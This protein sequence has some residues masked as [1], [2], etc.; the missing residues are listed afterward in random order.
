MV[1]AV[2]TSTH[3]VFLCLMLETWFPLLGVNL[4]NLS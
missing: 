4:P 1:K 2:L 3:H